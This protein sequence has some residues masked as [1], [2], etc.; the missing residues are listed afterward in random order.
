[1]SKFDTWLFL[2]IMEQYQNHKK[3]PKVRAQFT[4]AIKKGLQ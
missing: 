2:Q 3:S 4:N 1:M